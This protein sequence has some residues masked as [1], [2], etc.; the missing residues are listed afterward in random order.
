MMTGV[1]AIRHI[2]FAK[3]DY[4]GPFKPVHDRRVERRQELRMNPGAAGTRSKCRV[5]QIL[6]SDRNAV[7]RSAPDASGEFAVVLLCLRHRPLR[8]HNRVAVKAVSYT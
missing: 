3:R 4:A 6:Q 7:K 1:G 8:E 2:E 5:A